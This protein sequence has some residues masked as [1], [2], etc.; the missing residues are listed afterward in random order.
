[1]AP[2]A[3]IGLPALVESSRVPVYLMDPKENRILDANR[4]GCE[5]LGY[6][7]DELLR[8][9]VSRI[10]PAEL[11]QLRSFV[12]RAIEDGENWTVGLTCRTKS[13]RFLPT[14]IM[15]IAL[16]V[17]EHIYLVGMV[18]DRSEHRGP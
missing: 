17:G 4:A 8:T 11:A 18:R 12:D 2:R 13:G 16:T 5:L 1:V 9:P 6:R 10:H 15:L 14:E 3:E 7:R